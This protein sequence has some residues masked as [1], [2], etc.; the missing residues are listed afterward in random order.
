MD[1]DALVMGIAAV[2]AGVAVVMSVLA[3]SSSLFLFVVA[4][5]FG[6]AAYLLWDHASGRMAERVRSRRGR[7]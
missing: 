5:P 4:V 3:L 7:R 6:V 2:F 1:R